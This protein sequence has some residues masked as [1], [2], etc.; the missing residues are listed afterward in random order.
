MAP[1]APPTAA[2]SAVSAPRISLAAL[3]S[4]SLRFCS[5]LDAAS[6]VSSAPPVM[7]ALVS[8]S[9]IVSTFSGG[10]FS[11]SLVSVGRSAS[12]TTLARGMASSTPASN[13]RGAS[14]AFSRSSTVAS[15]ARARSLASPLAAAYPKPPKPVATAAPGAPSA[16]APKPAPAKPKRDPTPEATLY[17]GESGSPPSGRKKSAMLLIRS[18][19][20]VSSS[21]S[22]RLATPKLA[23]SPIP[24]RPAPNPVVMSSKMP[25][26][27]RGMAARN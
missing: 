6:C 1:A 3:Y 20:A 5:M 18:L 11:R 2:S 17:V 21:S 26:S 22:S 7:P 9:L 15:A 16:A 19:A 4:C 13:T 24:T 8:R 14:T 25:V 27:L 23:V 10:I 12:L